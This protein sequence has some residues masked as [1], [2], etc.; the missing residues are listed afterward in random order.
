[1]LIIVNKTNSKNTFPQAN[2]IHKVIKY[3]D[4]RTF[5]Y[6]HDKLANISLNFVKRQDSYYKSAANYLKL[7]NGNV[8]TEIALHIYKLDKNELFVNIVQ[9]ILEQEI[10]LD[11]Y[12]NRDPIKTVNLLKTNYL[13]TNST[14]KRR[15]STVKAWI[16]WCDQILKENKV[17]VEVESWI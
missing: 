12:L 8:P 17:L 16:G 5:Q 9:L 14:A 7:L 6:H 11:F 2:D 1:M 15:S 13:M 10:F 4:E 3:V